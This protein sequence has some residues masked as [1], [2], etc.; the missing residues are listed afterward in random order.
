MSSLPFPP[1]PT[2]EQSQKYHNFFVGSA[3]FGAIAL[4]LSI[5][6]PFYVGM[7]TQDK[8]MKGNNMCMTFGLVW[9][10]LF[11]MWISWSTFYQA[12]LWPYNA[13]VVG[14]E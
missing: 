5:T 2:V 7:K 3:I 10:A 12:Q 11:Y 6:L 9:L 13:I 14:A 1:A 8:S 4:V